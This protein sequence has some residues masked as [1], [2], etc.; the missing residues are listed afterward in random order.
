MLG[1]FI[2]VLENVFYLIFGIVSTSVLPFNRNH[3]VINLPR[4]D[5]IA[6]QGCVKESVVIKKLGVASEGRLGQYHYHSVCF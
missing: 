5:D 6:L 4:F 2:F 1:L 3:I